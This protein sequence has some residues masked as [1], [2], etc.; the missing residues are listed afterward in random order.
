MPSRHLRTAILFL[1]GLVVEIR[2]K[3]KPP[4]CLSTSV[5][6]Y[7]LLSLEGSS[8]F[9]CCGGEMMNE[10]DA[11]GDEDLENLEKYSITLGWALKQAAYG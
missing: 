9:G 7:V 8:L 1:Y 2:S 5:G 3:W 10:D 6:C 11:E 4:S